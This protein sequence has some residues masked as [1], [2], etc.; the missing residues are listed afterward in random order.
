[1]AAVLAASLWRVDSVRE[2]LAAGT[3]AAFWLGVE[4]LA[5]DP[6][7]LFPFAMG[8]AGAAVWRWSWAG[9]AA[10]GAAFL[11][12]RTAAG[13]PLGILQT[14]ALG[15]ALC[16]AAA[17]AARRAGPAAAAG[18]GSLAALIALLL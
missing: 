17:L 13:A 3:P 7:L 6:R 5:A 14:E 4:W 9:G 10:G 2:T 8:C 1:M 12:L 15:T 11:L 16:L 18:A